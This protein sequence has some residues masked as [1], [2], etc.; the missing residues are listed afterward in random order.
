MIFVTYRR[1]NQSENK[2]STF[3]YNY[4][5]FFFFRGAYKILLFHILL[6]ISIIYKGSPFFDCRMPEIHLRAPVPTDLWFTPTSIIWWISFE[7]HVAYFIEGFQRM[8]SRCWYS[9]TRYFQMFLI[10]DYPNYLIFYSNT[11]L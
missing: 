3:N 4:F 8:F 9:L 2:R 10:S 1:V 11:Y 6:R 7:C 5:Y